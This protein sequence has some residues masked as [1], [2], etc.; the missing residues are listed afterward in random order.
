MRLSI[1]IATALLACTCSP[2]VFAQEIPPSSS[3]SVDDPFADHTQRQNPPVAAVASFPRDEVSTDN[4]LSAVDDSF[5]ANEYRGG[6]LRL[7]FFQIDNMDARL[8]FGPDDLPLGGRIDLEKDLG[9]G[10]RLTAFRTSLTYRFN[11]RHGISAGY[12]KLNL[13]G[14]RRLSRTVELGGREFDIGFDIVSKYEE[15]IVKLAYNFIFHD[16]GKV[17]LS[18][19][20]GIHFSSVDFRIGT[21]NSLI[22]V[23]ES[24]STTAPLPMLGGRLVY[25]ITPKLSMAIVSDVFFLTRDDQEGSLTDTH[26][27]IEHQTFDRVGFGGGLNRFSLNLD[28]ADDGIL[29]DWESVYTGAY[30]FMNVK[31]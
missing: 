1:S 25:R 10:D 15:T 3:S 5:T 18:V 6:D 24:A 2:L 12:Y 13:D 4:A 11:E 9:F 30:V 7:G 19:T 16:E 21:R 29:W 28:L 17:L 31:F 26:I 8:Y 22:D 27:V 23:S 20:P 14:V